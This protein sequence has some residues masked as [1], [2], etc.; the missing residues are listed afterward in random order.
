[1][2]RFVQRGALRQPIARRIDP[3][4]LSPSA[5][6]TLYGLGLA[7]VTLLSASAA[8]LDLGAPTALAGIVTA[9]V[10]LFHRR[11][12]PWDLLKGISW[13][14]LPLVAGLFVLVEGLA[15]TGVVRQLSELLLASAGRSITTT[16]WAAGAAAAIACNLM[17]NLP[18]GLIA[19][20]VV[21]A[22]PLPQQLAAALMIGIDLGPNLSV[23][24]SLATILWLI[25]LRREGQEVSAWE[26]LR[27]GTV[28]TGPA[29]VL[30]LLVPA[31]QHLL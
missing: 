5:R 28:V 26:F 3:P 2:L 30:A 29:L 24:G 19:G 20:S 4:P 7:G 9:S 8:G 10:V 23:T 1:V 12:A 25:A 17:N 11:Q 18:V 16:S 27:L 31:L 22:G 21:A 15:Q 6:L 14:V 13:S